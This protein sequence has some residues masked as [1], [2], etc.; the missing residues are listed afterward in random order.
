MKLIT[1]FPFPTPPEAKSLVEVEVCL[2]SLE[3]LDSD[4]NL[5]PLDFI[6]ST[7]IVDK[8]IK[9]VLFRTCEQE[10][11]QVVFQMGT[12]DAVRALKAAELL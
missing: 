10:R 3:A 11:N 2:K 5:T 12:L 4:G 8:S 6:G 9:N 7:D 1:K